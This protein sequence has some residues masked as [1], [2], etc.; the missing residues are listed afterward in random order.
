MSIEDKFSEEEKGQII[1]EVDRERIDKFLLNRD[2]DIDGF[3]KGCYKQYLGYGHDDPMPFDDFVASDE[4]TDMIWD[5]EIKVG[6]WRTMDFVEKY[7]TSRYVNVNS[8]PSS[9]LR[10][11]EEIVA[12][13][14]SI[15]GDQYIKYEKMNMILDADKA[16]DLDEIERFAEIDIDNYIILGRLG[17]GAYKKAYIAKDLQRDMEVVLLQIDPSS[18]G[19]KLYAQIHHGLNEDQIKQKILEDEFSA[20]KIAFLLENTKN[21]AYMESPRQGTV[22][23]KRAFFIPTRRYTRTL[24]DVM[25]KG[26]IEANTAIRLY[27]QIASALANCFDAGIV[28]K[29]LK[30]DNIGIT[31]RGNILLTDFGCAGMFSEGSDARYQYPLELRPP[32]LAYGDEHWKEKG[33]KLQSELFTP[34][35]NIWTLG[36]IFYHMI[37]GE[38]V[39]ERPNPRAKTDTPE[40][41]AQNEA[42]Y[43]QIR[44]IDEEDPRFAPKMNFW[45]INFVLL[46]YKWNTWPGFTESTRKARA[47]ERLYNI[48]YDAAC[49]L[50]GCLEMD[51]KIREGKS[52]FQSKYY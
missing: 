50:S 18:H 26:K 48:D 2:D 10:P 44:N 16:K 5:G 19:F 17:E 51:P 36:M 24:A 32:E 1:A 35:A 49:I 28:H 6:D 45:H 20:S 40:Y 38:S 37:T 11:K 31:E 30:P 42:I 21:I 47:I 3:N 25:K 27:H 43:E 33:V 52:D 8:D 23:G 39:I 22:E 41:H 34:A 13:L 9:P 12:E 29:D 15:V 46:G 7:L 14:K 4:F